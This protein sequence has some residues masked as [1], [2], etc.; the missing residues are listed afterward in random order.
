MTPGT[1]SPR[2]ISVWALASS[3]SAPRRRGGFFLQSI[4]WTI[5]VCTAWGQEWN[6][7]VGFGIGVAL[8]VLIGAN[9]RVRRLIRRAIERRGGTV[10]AIHMSFA[11]FRVLYKSKS[12]ERRTVSC[13]VTGL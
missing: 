5:L 13:K 10:D 6:G 7:S 2:Y 8:C 3:A 11:W 12:M 9:F 1:G 4:F